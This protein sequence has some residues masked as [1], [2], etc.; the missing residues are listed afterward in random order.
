MALFEY[1]A[2]I[3]EFIGWFV[4]PL[5]LFV[6]ALNPGALMWLLLVAY[7]MGL[8]NSLIALLLDE[9]YGYFN[10]PTDTSRLVT[11]ALIENFGL[12]QMSVWW[13][14]RALLGGK[15]VVGWGNMERCGVGDLG[16]QE[17]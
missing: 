10:S 6:G 2:P 12:R 11:L 4:V 3:V 5:A 8:L 17:S 16:I 15:A 7:G 13:R 9:W 14:I 1:V